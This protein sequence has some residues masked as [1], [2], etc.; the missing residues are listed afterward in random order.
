MGQQPGRGGGVQ[1]VSTPAPDHAGQRR[2]RRGQMRPGMHTHH[3]LPL[4]CREFE[5]AREV[6]SGVGHENV[7]TAARPL[8][9]FNQRIDRRFVAHIHAGGGADAVEAA[10]G[11]FG[12]VAIQVRTYDRLGAFSRQPFRQRAPDAGTGAR[13]HRDP[14][15]NVH[16][17]SL[18]QTTPRHNSVM[19]YA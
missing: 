11:F 14:V 6:V 17:S 19:P 12:G 9:L 8:G 4:R 16:L 7:D 18:F 10:R 13:H 1:E 2:A 3:S 5:S 15:S